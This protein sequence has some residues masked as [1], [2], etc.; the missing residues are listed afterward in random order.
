LAIGDK[1]QNRG[2]REAEEPKIEQELIEPA[3]ER[4]EDQQRTA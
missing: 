3:I 1:I 2:R 4:Q